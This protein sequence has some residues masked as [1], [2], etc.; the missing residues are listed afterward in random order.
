MLCY[1]VNAYTNCIYPLKLNEY[2]AAGIPAIGSRIRTLRDHE[3]AVSLAS[4]PDQWAAA[5]RSALNP[6]SR[7]PEAVAARRSLA[8][9]HDW[10][11][12]AGRIATIITDGIARSPDQE[13]RRGI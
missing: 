5:I 13:G 2:L 3:H 9:N 10:N 4:G 12:I 11:Q 1:R 6:L 8:K 7:K